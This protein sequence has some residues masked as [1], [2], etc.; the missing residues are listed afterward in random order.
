MHSITT[1][2][3]T[4]NNRY[5]VSINNYC[6]VPRNSTKSY[7]MNY[8]EGRFRCT[9]LLILFRIFMVILVEVIVLDVKRTVSTVLQDRQMDWRSFLKDFIAMKLFSSWFQHKMASMCIPQRTQV[10]RICIITRWYPWAIIFPKYM[11]SYPHP[12]HPKISYNNFIYDL[13]PSF[14]TY[15][16]SWRTKITYNVFMY[17]TLLVLRPMSWSAM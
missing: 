7:K 8:E 1:F 9:I 12:W 10:C 6:F 13:V 2:W 3:F 17:D 15:P 16:L 4:H 14:M 11:I 5:L